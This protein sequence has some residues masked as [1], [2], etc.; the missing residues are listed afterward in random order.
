[1]RPGPKR[2][3][4]EERLWPKVDRRG[5]D[6]C[7]PWL[8][9]E[10]GHGYG[11]FTVYI[12]GKMRARAAHRVVYQ[13]LVGPIPEGLDLDHLCRSRIC[14]NPAHLEPVTRRENL[15][16]GITLPAAEVERTHCPRG[17][18]YD[19]VNTYLHGGQRHCRACRRE[20]MAAYYL[21]HK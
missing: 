9:S 5:D 2:R 13:L 16:R 8:A 19:E 18:A 11:Q 1:M 21:A 17:H 20:R 10:N 3:T 4:L 7:W 12:D 15:L 6:E 14:V